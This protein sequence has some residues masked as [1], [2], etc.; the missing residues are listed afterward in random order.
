LIADELAMLNSPSEETGRAKG[1]LTIVIRKPSTV[2]FTVKRMQPYE[3][4]N[5]CQ[6]VD[7][8]IDGILRTAYLRKVSTMLPMAAIGRRLT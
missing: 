8:I 5:W 3:N 7:V 1:C 6:R 2:H 4:S